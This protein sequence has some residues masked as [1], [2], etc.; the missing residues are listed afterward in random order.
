MYYPSDANILVE[1]TSYTLYDARRSPRS[2]YHLYPATSLFLEHANAGDLVAV[3]PA[4]RSDDLCILVAERGGQPEA[5]ILV[6]YFPHGAP[7]LERFVFVDTGPRVETNSEVISTIQALA[8][9][10]DFE[11]R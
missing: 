8:H 10:L 2:E 1:E 11:L 6:A 9:A 4:A 3:L 7:S 5:D